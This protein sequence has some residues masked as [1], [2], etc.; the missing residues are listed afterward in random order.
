VILAGVGGVKGALVYSHPP[1]PGLF[2]F[3]VRG[4]LGVFLV[5]P[6]GKSWYWGGRR[7]QLRSRGQGS[8]QAFIRRA[9]P[10]QERS[11]GEFKK[12]RG[13]AKGGGRNGGGNTF[14]SD[15]TYDF[16]RTQ[17]EGGRRP[18]GP[19]FARFPTALPSSTQPGRGGLGAGYVTPGNV[20]HGRDPPPAKPPENEGTKTADHNQSKMGK[21]A[22]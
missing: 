7:R 1:W 4:E 20:R 11:T 15:P 17:G 5:P 2:L 14:C 3:A 18:G 10:A 8:E 9:S 16:L 12:T 22:Q 13:W 19:G 21:G 6:G